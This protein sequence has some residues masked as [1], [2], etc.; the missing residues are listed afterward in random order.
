MS[1]M[2]DPGTVPSPGQQPRQRLSSAERRR[3][4]LSAARGEFARLG[5]HGASTNRIAK[6]AGCSE[7]M[8]YKHFCSKLELFLEALRDSITS[9]QTWFDETLDPD[10][11]VS[12]QAARMVAIELQD[13]AFHELLQ[14]RMLAV[15]LADKGQVREV[16]AE[17]E[18]STQERI[19]ALVER[20]Q[21][22]GT[23]RTDIDPLFAAWGWLGLML[24]TC[25]RESWEPGSMPSMSTHVTTFIRLLAPPSTGS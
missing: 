13:P 9:F 6:A 18:R 7:P 14:L 23:M 1:S 24:A 16:L 19:V 5:F 21:R 15:G 8:L 17:L 25:Y 11:D 10:L 3:T 2:S 4:I 20:G 12:Q 22:Q